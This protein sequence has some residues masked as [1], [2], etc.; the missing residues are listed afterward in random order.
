MLFN[1][2]VTLRAIICHGSIATLVAALAAG[3]IAHADLVNFSGGNLVLMRG[4]DSAFD[5]ATYSTGQVPAY[6]DEYSVSVSGGVATASFVG[7]YPI[8]VATLTLP[9]IAANSH[10]GRLELSGDGNFLDFGGYQQPLS[11]A[12]PR[13]TDGTG[14]V[15]YLQVGQV[16]GTGALVSAGLNTGATNP[17]FIRA[18]YS[19]DGTQA[20]VAS[21]SPNGGLDYV[22]GIGTSPTTTTLQGTT[23]WRDLKVNSGQLY[24]GTGSSSVGTHGFY[25]IGSG[26]PILP[27]PVNTLLGPNSD[28]SASGFAFATLP[29]GTAPIN[30]VSGPNVIYTVGDPSGNNYIGKLY[31]DGAHGAPL[32]ASN[33]VFAGG[34]RLA[35]G[36]AIPGPEGVLAKVDP[37]NSA[38][39]DL[40]V[41][42]AD[43]VYFGVDKSGTSSGSIASLSFTKIIGTGSNV[44]IPNGG[45]LYGI[46]SA[47]NAVPEPSTLT[48]IGMA[49]IGAVA[50]CRRRRA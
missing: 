46:S 15:G 40:F 43:G 48:L 22:S 23:D 41:Q 21:K 2:S 26:S 6:L 33:L 18:A 29:G 9:G 35:L 34:A 25:S 31:N 14:G 47:P 39:V 5:Q 3:S 19:N 28:N 27:T 49:S 4:G 42:N 38:W 7:Q 44:L 36:A 17:Q 12:T 8:P 45:A 20:W 11:P 16:A 13:K 50:A 1:R 24:G 30:G 32:T 37:D 10:E